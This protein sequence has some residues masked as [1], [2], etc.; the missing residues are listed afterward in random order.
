MW[1]YFEKFIWLMK[2]EALADLMASLFP[3]MMTAMPPGMVPMMKSMK[4]V[5]GGLD[6][7]EKMM[8]A[9]F[10]DADA[11]HHAQGDARHAR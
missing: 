3:Q 10:P 8:P 4:Y 5:P 6:L 7:M 9:M 11:V 2:P 1:G